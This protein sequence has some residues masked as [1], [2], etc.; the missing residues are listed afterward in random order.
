MITKKKMPLQRQKEFQKNPNFRI[1]RTERHSGT[2]IKVIRTVKPILATP[3][4]IC[5]LTGS[6][7]VSKIKLSDQLPNKVHALRQKVHKHEAEA[8]ERSRA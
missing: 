7:N 5:K 4:H 3:V 1:H 2:S 8:G 6:I